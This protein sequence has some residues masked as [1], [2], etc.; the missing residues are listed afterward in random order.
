MREAL[1]MQA[2]SSSKI[3]AALI[4]Q[5]V[6]LVVQEPYQDKPRT[7]YGCVESIEGNFLLFKTK[8]GLG[9]FNVNFV[10]AIKPQEG[11]P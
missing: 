1:T 2:G 10:I 6:K 8:K 11:R 9:S 7:Y 3:F 5:Q 4:G